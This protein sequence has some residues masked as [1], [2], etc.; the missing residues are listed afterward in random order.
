MQKCNAPVTLALRGDS[1]PEPS[2]ERPHKARRRPPH[3]VLCPHPAASKPE[4]AQGSGV[5]GGQCRPRAAGSEAPVTSARSTCP[6]RPRCS[7]GCTCGLAAAGGKAGHWGVSRP[8]PRPAPRPLAPRILP[9]GALQAQTYPSASVTGRR[10]AGGA[11][12]RRGSHS[13]GWRRGCLSLS[14]LP[15]PRPGYP[16][17][18][19]GRGQGRRAHTVANRPL[20]TARRAP[21]TGATGWQEPLLAGAL[22]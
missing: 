6:P 21:W 8:V 9:A 1:S 11:Q 16:A 20:P 3:R 19:R 12:G 15:L 7:P 2:T 4:G 5:A 18:S 17:P 14:L 13:C 10:V 22:L